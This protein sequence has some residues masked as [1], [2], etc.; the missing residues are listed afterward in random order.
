[1]FFK[2]KKEIVVL[3]N[4]NGETNNISLILVDFSFQLSNLKKHYSKEQYNKL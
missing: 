4:S 3:T 2:V 1:M